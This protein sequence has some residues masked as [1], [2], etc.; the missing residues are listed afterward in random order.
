MLVHVG[1]LNDRA[2]GRCEHVRGGGVQHR[3]DRERLVEGE[4]SRFLY[5]IL[6]GLRVDSEQRRLAHRGFDAFSGV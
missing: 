5:P 2:L 4:A 3:G 1:D 6:I